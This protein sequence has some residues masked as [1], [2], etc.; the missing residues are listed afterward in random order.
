VRSLIWPVTK[1][2]KPTLRTKKTE[3]YK[4]MSNKL[5]KVEHGGEV[6]PDRKDKGSDADIKRHKYGIPEDASRE[7]AASEHEGH[8]D[9]AAD[10]VTHTPTPAGPLY[11][12]DPKQG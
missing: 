6:Q 10:Q 11:N 3:T 8:D 5:Q 9:A 7:S 2:L 12:D 4:K 1:S